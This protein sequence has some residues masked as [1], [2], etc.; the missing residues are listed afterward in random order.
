MGLSP[1]IFSSG[2]ASSLSWNTVNLGDGSW[3][4]ATDPD[5]IIDTASTTSGLTTFT[6][7]TVN[8]GSNDYD[9]G[10][11]ATNAR[12]WRVSKE[13]VVDGAALTGSD[14]FVFVAQIIN[15][16]GF[17]AEGDAEIGLCL[18]QTPASTA[19]STFLGA[20][21]TERHINAAADPDYASFNHTGAAQQGNAGIHTGT[22]FIGVDNGLLT[23]IGVTAF[24][25]TTPYG[26]ASRPA[27]ITYTTE[28]FHVA[29]CAGSRAGGTLTTGNRSAAQ[30]RWAVITL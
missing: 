22:V 16:S 20:G 25:G 5:G 2:S 27:N 12:F 30:L 7:N 6:Y 11:N 1:L 14:S 9:I 8:P 10:G 21:I 23:E 15:T 18:A 13:L 26:P 24:D 28:T 29:V 3:S 4:A 19:R 17:L